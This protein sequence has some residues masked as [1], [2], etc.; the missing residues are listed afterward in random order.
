LNLPNW[1]NLFNKIDTSRVKILPISIDEQ[2][3]TLNYIINNNIPF[4]A[5]Y[6][7]KERFLL[8]YK[9]FITPQTILISNEGKVINVWKG[10][11]DKNSIDE[12]INL[13]TN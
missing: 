5:F 10:V 11:L 1:I 6:T 9:A 2:K 13:S 8:D 12:I 3:T 4:K 7:T